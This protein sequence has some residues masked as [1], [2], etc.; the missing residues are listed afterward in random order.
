[1]LTLLAHCPSVAWVW[2]LTSFSR[3]NVVKSREFILAGFLFVNIDVFA[4]IVQTALS[5]SDESENLIT[6]SVG[7]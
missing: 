1:M 2:L 3:L 6:S 5:E 7:K 4:L